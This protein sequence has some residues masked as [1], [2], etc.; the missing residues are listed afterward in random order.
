MVFSSIAQS[1]FDEFPFRRGTPRKPSSGFFFLSHA[2]SDHTSGLRSSLSDPD[3]TIVCSKETAAVIKVLYGI[4][5]EKCLEIKSS[6]SLDFDNFIVHAIDANHCVGS[7]SF[8]I[9]S[10]D[11]LR[12]VYTG[13]FRLGVPIF[14][15]LR[16]IQETD[17]LWVDYTYGIDP[18]FR[19][20]S[21]EEIIS[22]IITL[23]LS[24]GNFPERDVWISSYQIGKEKLLKT[25]SDALKVK[26]WASDLKVK[27][28]KEIGGE[29]DIF[30]NDRDSGVFVGSRRMVERLHGIDKQYHDKMT[31]ALRI[32]PTGWAS[33]L[34]Q[35]HLDV[36]F[37]PYSDHCSYSEVHKFIKLVN[38]KRI[39]KI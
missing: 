27:T 33:R 26:I 39:K 7:L 38:A 31:E 10:K 9:E 17:H 36:N 32:S 20:P 11:G 35:K 4:P 3:A 16:L 29:W 28:Y 22:E 12:E 34:H 30:T 6:Q 25:I 13:D 1:Y 8:V 14:D 23:I 37:F 21:R 18:I 24:E 19:F 15:E 2:H 5:R